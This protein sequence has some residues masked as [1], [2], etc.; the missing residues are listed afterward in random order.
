[1]QGLWLLG[2]GPGGVPEGAFLVYQGH[3]GEAGAGQAVVFL[4]GAA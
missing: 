3:H 1:V 4:P 2:S